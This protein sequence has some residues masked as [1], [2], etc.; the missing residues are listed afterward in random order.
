MYFDIYYVILVLPTVILALIAQARVK[1]TFNTYS[2]VFN[3]RGMTGAQ[4]AEAILHGA[5]IYDVQIMPIQ[6]SLT[7]NYNPSTKVVSLSESVYGSTS[8]AAA[9]VAAHECGHAIQHHVGYAPLQFR[10]AIIP[11]TQIGSRLSMPLILAGLVF[12]YFTSGSY[13]GSN[14]AYTLIYI[15]IAAFGLSVLFQVVTV[16]VEFNASRRA[17]DILGSSQLL[18]QDEVGHAKKVL[19]AAA[20]TYVAAMAQSLAMLLRLLLIFGRDRD[21]R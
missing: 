19:S 10:N 9:G 16:P 14:F 1:S 2:K 6:G 8:I 5:G 7:D 15:G 18:E 20:M 3:R 17:L 4:V 13:A 11:I 12:T 21:R